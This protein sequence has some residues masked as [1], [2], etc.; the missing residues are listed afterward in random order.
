ME[1][2][3]R[4]DAQA[5]LADAVPGFDAV[6]QQFLQASPAPRNAY[7][8]QHLDRLSAR[9]QIRACAACSWI[10]CAGAARWTRTPTPS[11]G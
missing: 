1:A 6:A 8:T 10:L 7:E 5:I 2:V 9:C 11:C 4:D 3:I